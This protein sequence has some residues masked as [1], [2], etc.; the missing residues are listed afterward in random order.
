MPARGDITDLLHAWGGGDADALERLFAIVYEELERLAHAQLR[1]ERPGHTLDTGALVHEAYFRLIEL[2][3][4]RWQNRAHFFAMAARAMRQV[5]VG[6]AVAR[7][8]K[9]RGSGR[10]ALP[11]DEAVVMVESRSDDLLAL[12]EALA[13]LER[14]EPRY[15][16]VVECRLF[17]GLNIEETA[18]ALDISPATVK[19]DWTLARAWLNQELSA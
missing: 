7:N 8:A 13:R 18:A 16:R 5:L 14:A 3:P 12:D 9:K 17:A 4:T 2:D 11:L 1:R 15:V 10:T 19:R 6:Y